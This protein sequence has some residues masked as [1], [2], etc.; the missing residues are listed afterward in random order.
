M[1]LMNYRGIC[2]F[3]FVLLTIFSN[4]QS[5]QGSGGILVSVIYDFD[6]LDIGEKDLPD[7]DFRNHDLNY[8][9]AANPLGQSDVL[10]DRVVKIRM[11]WN[12][13]FGEFG[14]ATMRFVEL[15]SQ[16]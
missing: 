5:P 7:G 2:F 1:R 8:E 6:G 16:T 11:N 9:I 14:K 10:G 4:S 13:G 3:Y 12:E 15:N